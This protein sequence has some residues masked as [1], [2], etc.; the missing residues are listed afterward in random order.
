MLDDRRWTV[1][2]ESRVEVEAER[3]ELWVEKCELL[4]VYCEEGAKD[5]DKGIFG[6]DPGPTCVTRL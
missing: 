6:S 3:S 5:V 1:L 2:E 4:F